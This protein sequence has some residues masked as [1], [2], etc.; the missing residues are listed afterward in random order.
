MSS[1]RP[2]IQ[3]AQTEPLPR[4][5]VELPSRPA[6]FFSNLRDLILPPQLS[7]LELQSAP[8][9]FWP[10]VF[11]RRPLP[12]SKFLQSAVY[13]G[14]AGAIVVA[15]GHLFAMQPRG[16]VQPS[17]DHSQVVYYQT[18]EYL[19]PLDTRSQSPS[20]AVK[21]DPEFSKQPIISVPPEAD[22]PSQT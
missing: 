7:P 18:A 16:V 10:D 6:I 21:A 22:N 4:L 11:V 17:F 14:L 12:W 5:L 2:T 3:V 19:P 13:H 20:R 1:V 15:L 8:G 9:E